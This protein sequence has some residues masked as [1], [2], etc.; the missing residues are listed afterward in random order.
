M[1]TKE[2]QSGNETSYIYNQ[3]MKYPKVTTDLSF[4]T[5]TT[6]PLE[7]YS[8]IELDDFV[9]SPT[10]DSAQSGSV[11]NDVRSSKEGLPQWRKH[12]TS[13]IKIVEDLFKSRISIDKIAFFHYIFLNCMM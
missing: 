8:G 9:L 3:M 13:E 10:E 5:I 1:S 12:M 6:M 11:S 4:V 2:N 7:H